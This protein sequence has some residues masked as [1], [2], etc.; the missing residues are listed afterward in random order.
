MLTFEAF[1]SALVIG[2]TW[3]AKLE[4]FVRFL[5][6]TDGHYDVTA[7]AAGAAEYWRRGG[8]ECFHAQY[9]SVPMDPVTL[10]YLVGLSPGLQAVLIHKVSQIE[11]VV[12][13]RGDVL[14]GLDRERRVVHL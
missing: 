12:S 10:D 7:I 14:L 6:R 3:S 13:R 4:K 2:F 11:C 5:P 9:P 1:V 8:G